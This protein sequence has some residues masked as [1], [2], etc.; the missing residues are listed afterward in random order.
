L[1]CDRQGA[2][3][4]AALLAAWNKGIS[5]LVPVFEPEVFFHTDA[6]SYE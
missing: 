2:P 3:S 4:D 1:K 5:I 6:L